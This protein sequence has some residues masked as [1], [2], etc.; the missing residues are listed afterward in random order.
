MERKRKIGLAILMLVLGLFVLVPTIANALPLSPGLTTEFELQEAPTRPPLEPPSDT[1]FRPLAIDLS[2]LKGDRMPEGV[3]VAA[4]PARFDWRDQGVVTRVQDQNPCGACYA[5]ASLANIESKL[6]IDG[7]GVFDFSENNA[8]ECPW[9]DPSCGGSNYWEMAGW[10]SSRGTVLETCDPYV[11]RDVSCKTTCPYIKTLLD[12][13]FISSEVP[14][15]N[16]LKGYIQ[17]YGP[18]YAGMYVQK[19][20]SW[21]DEFA[22]YN[23]SYTLYYEGT[24]NPNHAVLIVGWDDNLTHAGGKGAWIVKN[25]W[26]TDWGGICGYGAERGYFTIAYGSASI[27]KHSSFIYAWQ[28]YNPN[29]GIMYYDEVGL[30]TA[31]G[32]RNSTTGWGLCKFT[33]PTSTVTRV[34]F[35]TTDRTIDVDVYIYDDFDGTLSNLLWS[36]L[37]HNFD[38]AGYHGIV[39]DPP[40]AVTNGND[41]IVVVKFTNQNFQMPIP[42]DS[43]GP[44]ET[45][46]TFISCDGSSGSWY[47]LGVGKRDDVAIRLRTSGIIPPTPLIGIKVCLPLCLKSHVPTPFLFRLNLPVCLKNYGTPIK[48]D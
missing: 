19:Y 1:G 14:D 7:A 5:F 25:S 3:K 42:A 32:C 9:R 28:D 16:V 18:V 46:R 11:A 38:E 41:V 12:M 37:N 45:G 39:V 36:S 24:G 44:H 30:T 26:G 2:H 4:L 17:T 20:G 23:G 8:K 31:W 33:P 10:L 6:Q 34:E 40:L 13:R 29:G 21:H 35:Y 43:E 22:R 48:L 47:D 15:T 27:G